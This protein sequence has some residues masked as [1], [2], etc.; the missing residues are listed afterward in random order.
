MFAHPTWCGDREFDFDF[1]EIFPALVEENL[2]LSGSNPDCSNV[3]GSFGV[4]CFLHP[5]CL[6]YRYVIH[7][8]A[9]GSRQL[10]VWSELKAPS[11]KPRTLYREPRTVRPSEPRRQPHSPHPPLRG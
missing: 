4:P 7:E 10:A 1:D 3:K 8:L 9:V 11:W 5:I 6:I 2:H